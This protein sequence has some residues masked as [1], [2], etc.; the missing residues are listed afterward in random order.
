M[1]MPE[2]VLQAHNINLQPRITQLL[3]CETGAAMSLELTNAAQMIKS[4]HESV[5]NNILQGRLCIHRL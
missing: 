5:V 4:P 2:E 1:D 3:F